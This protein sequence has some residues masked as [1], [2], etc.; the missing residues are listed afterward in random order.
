MEAFPVDSRGTV[1]GIIS[2]NRRRIVFEESAG[3]FLFAVVLN[4]RSAER[5]FLHKRRR[6]RALTLTCNA[7]VATR[8]RVQGIDGRTGYT[9]LRKNF[10]IL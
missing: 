2:H 7:T 10:L 6:L 4:R 1:S 3:A 9:L 5:R 8:R